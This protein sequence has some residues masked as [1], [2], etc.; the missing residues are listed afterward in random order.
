[1]TPSIASVG[2]FFRR[3]FHKRNIIIVSE[4]KVNHVPV[5]GYIQFIV[6]F[7]VIGG[8]CL[9]SYSTGKFMAVRSALKQQTQALRTVTNAHIETSFNNVYQAP[10]AEEDIASSNV[11]YRG[12]TPSNVLETGPTAALSGMD[13]A[14]LIARIALLENKVTELKNTNEVIVQRVHDKALGQLGDLENMIKHTGLDLSELKKEHMEEN[15]TDKAQNDHKVPSEGGPYIPDEAVTPQEKEMFVSLDALTLMRQI[16]MNLPLAMPIENANEESGFGRRV[17][18]FN[19]HLAFHSGL[20]LAGPI[21]AEIHCTADGTVTAAGRNGGYGNAI[22]IDH[23][24][25]ISTRYGH[26]SEIRV[27]EGQVVKKGDVI[28]V[29]GSTGRSTGP[30]LHYEVRYHDQAINPKNFLEAGQ[31]VSQK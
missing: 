29:Q 1:M 3:W 9:A 13:N 27:H 16:V 25:G 2:I 24:F 4:R 12:A 18:P 14:K 8:V 19:E 10:P 11:P 5:S 30:H 15:K 23:G 7:A 28:G 21:G 26:L 22:D 20:D 31:Y 6:L 17:D